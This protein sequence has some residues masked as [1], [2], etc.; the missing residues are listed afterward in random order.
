MKTE[1][2]PPGTLFVRDRLLRFLNQ[3]TA[4][5]IKNQLWWLPKE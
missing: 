1:P 2:V 4:D 3:R 5:E